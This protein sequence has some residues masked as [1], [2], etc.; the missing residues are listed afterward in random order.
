MKR[1]IISIAAL[2]VLTS[3]LAQVPGTLSYQGILVTGAGAPVADGD[4]TVSFKFYTVAT[5]GTAVFTRGPFTVVTYKGMFTF[6]L[7][8][9]TPTGNDPLPVLAADPNYIGGSQYYVELFADNVTL[10]PRVQ[11]SSVPY[12]FAAHNATTMSAAGLTGTANLP[13]TV[14]DTDVQD[15][16]DGLLSGAKVG[17]GIDAA[18]ITTNSLALSNG[19]T[20]ATTAAG[21]RT[22][23]GLG[24]LA[25]ANAITT[26]EITD[27]SIVG[28][29]INATAA[30]AD[31]KLSTISTAGKVSGDAI[32]FGTIGG[33]TAINTSGNI[34]TSG[35][36]TLTVGGTSTLIGAIGL[37]TTPD[38]GTTG[39]VLTSQGVGAA[40]I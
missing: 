39:K 12:A 8:T 14:L 13:S 22:N 10:A 1:I 32:T 18:N 17:T 35:T 29:D 25:T 37:G 38:F 9:A 33:T 30:I 5:G 24:S 7:G 4:H 28:A 19:G 21:A 20:G 11:L 40:P 31:T 23:L 16:A 27:G 3:G 36:G 6:V 15:L 26:T 34:A 2:L